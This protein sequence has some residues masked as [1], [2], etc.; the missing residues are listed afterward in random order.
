MKKIL[1][2]LLAGISLSTVAN[3]QLANGVV[4]PDWTR[5]DLNGVTH[6]LYADLDSGYTVFIDL[7]AAWCGPCW[8]YHNSGA[9]EGLYN[10]HGPA[11]DNKVRVYF[12]EGE[13][14]NTTAQLMGTSTNT[15]HDGYTQGNW[16]TGTPYP[17]IDTNAAA[18]TA[19]NQAWGFPGYPNEYSFPTIYMVCRDRLV[20]NV[21]QATQANLEAAMNAGCPNYAP[22][23]TYD[24]KAIDYSGQTTFVCNANPTVKFQNYSTTNN[25]TAATIKVMQGATVMA[26]V[27]WTG[28]LAPYAIATVNVPSF[29]ATVFEPYKFTVTVAGDT[30]AANDGKDSI[31]RIYSAANVATIPF[32][33]NLES[34]PNF[35]VKFGPSADGNIFLYSGTSPLL[36]GADGNATRAMAFNFYNMQTNTTTEVVLG[37]YNTAA[38]TANLV[39]GFDVAAA[40][41]TAATPENDKLEVLVSN[42]CGGSWHT[43]WSKAGTTLYS[44]PAPNPAGQFIPTLASQWRHEVADMSAYTG[45][46]LTVKMKG[47]SGFGNFAWVDNFNIHNATAVNNVVNENTVSL[48]PNPA[49]DKATLQ[50]SLVAASKVQV[51]VIDAMGRV[52]TNV[53]DQQMNAGVNTVNINTAN[54]ASGIYNVKITTEGN[55]TTQRLTVAK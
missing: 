4:A 3:A 47:T 10:T 31:I 16:V 22:S 8:A 50:F 29:A 12:I 28:N 14:T 27:P 19:F 32:V 33:E 42:D 38:V 44:A 41:Y 34:S 48:F 39:L 18:T 2:T 53:A 13:S 7:S 6:H 52:V 37:N 46:N 49:T 25:I 30:Y 23:A 17:I 5:V 36:N 54:L 15:N 40:P 21:G 20:Y 26:T 43:V 51:Q 45:S 24:A 35:P 11:G 9:L 55:V 1:L